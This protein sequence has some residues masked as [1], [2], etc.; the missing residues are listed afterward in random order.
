M[1]KFIISI[2]ILV[3]MAF[4]NGDEREAPDNCVQKVVNA[5]QDAAPSQTGQ[6][7]VSIL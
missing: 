6:G 1:V 7:I 4:A 5:S 3:V 2:L